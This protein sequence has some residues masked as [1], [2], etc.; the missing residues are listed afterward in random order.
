MRNLLRRFLDSRKLAGM[1]LAA[2]IAAAAVVTLT[3]PPARAGHDL[4]AIQQKII[5]FKVGC[6]TAGSIISF[7]TA[8]TQE[9]RQALWAKAIGSGECLENPSRFSAYFVA[10]VTKLRWIDGNRIVVLEGHSPGGGVVFTWFT[11]DYWKALGIKP[12]SQPI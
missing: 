6:Y 8:P 2:A 4:P 11:E 3:A 5:S 1:I 12:L 10:V 7:A 9:I